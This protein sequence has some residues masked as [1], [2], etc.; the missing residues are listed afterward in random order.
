MTLRKYLV[1]LRGQGAAQRFAGGSADRDVHRDAP[2][3]RVTDPP[4]R[5]VLCGFVEP[6]TRPESDDL[7]RARGTACLRLRPARGGDDPRGRRRVGLGRLVLPGESVVLP[8]CES[9]SKH[10]ADRERRD[11]AAR[12]STTSWSVSPRRALWFL[13]SLMLP[14]REQLAPGLAR[15][16]PVPVA[17]FERHPLNLNSCRWQR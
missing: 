17:V 11:P 1:P 7:G 8:R 4:P 2:E 3:T 12:W 9:E 10:C 6:G 15:L 16:L 13:R 5:D 14:S